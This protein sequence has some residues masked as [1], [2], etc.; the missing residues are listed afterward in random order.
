MSTGVG[1]CREH[2]CLRFDVLDHLRKTEAR[3]V[4]VAVLVERGEGIS[5]EDVH[6]RQEFQKRQGSGLNAPEMVLGDHVSHVKIGVWRRDDTP[7][8]EGRVTFLTVKEAQNRN[9][10]R[11][12]TLVMSKHHG[13]DTTR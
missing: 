2:L 11:S 10:G 4:G 1:S 3:P 6:G 12:H 5:H 13:A 8:H 9:V 7:K